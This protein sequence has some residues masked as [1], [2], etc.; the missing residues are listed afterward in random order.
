MYE[1][2]FFFFEINYVLWTND[3]NAENFSKRM[4][5]C[6]K[7]KKK[8]PSDKM[9][10]KKKK[11]DVVGAWFEIYNREFCEIRPSEST[12]ECNAIYQRF[13]NL[14]NTADITVELYSAIDFRTV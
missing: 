11:W 2:N 14:A 12:F 7:K 9:I 5:F 13:K 6:V 10:K 4:A 1:S 8:R 3:T